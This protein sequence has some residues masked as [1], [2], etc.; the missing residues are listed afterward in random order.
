LVFTCDNI[1]ASFFTIASNREAA[2]LAQDINKAK[3][4]RA[5]RILQPRSDETDKTWAMIKE[6][7]EKL[8][9]HEISIQIREHENQ[10]TLLMFHIDYYGVLHCCVLNGEVHLISFPAIHQEDL[11]SKVKMLLKPCNIDI[12]R[13]FSF[14]A[15]REDEIDPMSTKTRTA[16]KD[17][18]RGQGNMNAPK[19]PKP[20]S[21][22]PLQK[23]T[24]KL[25]EMNVRWARKHVF[26]ILLHPL[27]NFIKGTK[28]IIIPDKFLFLLP[29]S[30]LLDESDKSLSMTYN[31]QIVP[32]LHYLLL[33]L[34]D[35][36]HSPTIGPA[37]CIGNPNLDAIAKHESEQGI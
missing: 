26:K 5:D 13:G 30:C 34:A 3:R 27:E 10:S 21:L 22:T 8:R 35:S 2:F 28:L 15:D 32:A 23:A 18:E 6:D 1:V 20:P 16:E 11:I 12:P 24:A 36:A 17:T 33:C 14:F 25:R 4:I 7:K 29:F 9:L 19:P 37:M 31:I